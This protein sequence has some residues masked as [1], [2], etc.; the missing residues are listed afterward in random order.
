[1]SFPR[2]TH[3]TCL[4]LCCSRSR[5][6]HQLLKVKLLPWCKPLKGEDHARQ[7]GKVQ[8]NSLQPGHRLSCATPF[9][10]QVPAQSWDI[11]PLKECFCPGCFSPV[12]SAVASQKSDPSDASSAGRKRISSSSSRNLLGPG[13]ALSCSQ[14]CPEMEPI[15]KFMGST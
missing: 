5:F 14:N 7:P 10:L 2:P 15:W 4:C 1:M 8:N 13:R 6:D 11:P 3:Q 12:P 9:P